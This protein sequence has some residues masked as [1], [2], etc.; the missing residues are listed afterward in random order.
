MIGPFFKN[1]FSLVILLNFFLSNLL[2]GQ[3]ISYDQKIQT[4]VDLVNEDT[5]RHHVSELCLAEGYQ[6]RVTFTPGNYYA[7]E[8]IAQYFQLLQL[9]Y[10]QLI[11]MQ[12]QIQQLIFAQVQTRL[13]PEILVL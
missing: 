3:S 5:L 1:N 13:H 10:Q 11:L 12:L 7:A 6:S 8:Y 2:L 4:M 9:N